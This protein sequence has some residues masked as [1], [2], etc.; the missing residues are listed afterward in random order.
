MWICGFFDTP[1]YRYSAAQTLFEQKKSC[2][3]R[4]NDEIDRSL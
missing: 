2:Q 4:Q 3:I 1:E